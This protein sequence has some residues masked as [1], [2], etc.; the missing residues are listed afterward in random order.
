MKRCR[1]VQNHAVDGDD[2]RADLS[3]QIPPFGRKLKSASVSGLNR[4]ESSEEES[5]IAE[6]SLRHCG[7]GG[8][9]GVCLAYGGV[10]DSAMADISTQETHFEDNDALVGG[11]AGSRETFFFLIP[12]R[13]W[14][15]REHR[16]QLEH[17]R[18]YKV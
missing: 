12:R 18:R 7:N 8:G 15:V 9:G 14:H 6:D 13:R 5:V 1:F 10:P 11:N 2:L 4:R 17:R 16:R 3:A